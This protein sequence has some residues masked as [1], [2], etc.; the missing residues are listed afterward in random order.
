VR[1]LGINEVII[2]SHKRGPRTGAVLNFWKK[3]NQ[4]IHGIFRYAQIPKI[5][6]KWEEYLLYPTLWSSRMEI[7]MIQLKHV[8]M[9]WQS[10][11]MDS[12]FLQ[13]HTFYNHQF[14]LFQICNINLWIVFRIDTLVWWWL[15][16]IA[17]P[18]WLNFAV[19]PWVPEVAIPS[20]PWNRVLF[21][22]FT[23]AYT[24]QNCDLSVC[25]DH[26]N[27]D[28]S[29]CL[30]YRPISHLSFLSKTLERLV[31]LQLIPSSNKWVFCLLQSGFRVHQSNQMKSIFVYLMEK[32]PRLSQMQ[33]WFTEY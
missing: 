26:H 6:A 28:P 18:T 15:L 13:W 21:V 14:H 33:R 19:P 31:V 29:T 9:P 22:R 24:R 4:F 11:N 16:G 23:H 10:Q 27:L 7:Y 5:E 12:Q 32:V 25:K 30:N 8:Q 17:P 20:A 2:I 3:W 1:W